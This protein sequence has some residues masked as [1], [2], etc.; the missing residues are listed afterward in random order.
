MK[1][2][3]LPEDGG[4]YQYLAQELEDGHLK[5]VR[6]GLVQNGMGC[7]PWVLVGRDDGILYMTG[8]G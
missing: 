1:H 8:K 6:D 7:H 4:C 2:I 5:A 3:V